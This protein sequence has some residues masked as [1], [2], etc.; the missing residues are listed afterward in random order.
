MTDIIATLSG[1]MTD[2]LDEDVTLTR[3]TVADDVEGWDSL[4][5]IRFVLLT[6][7]TFKIKFSAAEIS[8][9]KSVGELADCIAAKLA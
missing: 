4:C 3:D 8:G 1:I 5:N 9:F 7:S 6:E 2:I